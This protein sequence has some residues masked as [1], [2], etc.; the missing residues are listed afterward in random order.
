MGELKK[1]G[2][3][4]YMDEK[5]D[6]WVSKSLAGEANEREETLL[7]DVLLANEEHAR[8]YGQISEYW[9]AE[10]CTDHHLLDDVAQKMSG[11]I[12]GKRR[13]TEQR[14]L[15]LT[16]WRA[17]A[18]VLLLITCGTIMY[19]G[20]RPAKTYTCYATQENTAD[21]TLADGSFVKLNKNSTISFTGDF[22]QKDRVVELKG[23]AYFKIVKDPQKQ[24]VVKTQGT[25]TKVLGTQFNVL[26]DETAKRVTVALVKGSVRFEAAHCRQILKPEDELT[27]N[28]KTQ[29]YV[30]Q[31]PDIQFNT[32]WAEGRY[33]YRNI[34][35]GELLKK[36]EH[37]YGIN[38]E[39]QDADLQIRIVTVSLLT[40]STITDA[41]DALRDKLNFSY[42]EANGTITIEKI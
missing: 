26:S 30:K 24:F 22:G 31:L 20:A 13:H 28:V 40:N 33:Y 14:S 1:T 39:L 5:F 37:I 27:Y 41:L 42:R 32:A 29:K 35:F 16:F 23:E 11:E 34:T 17:A 2:V 21:Y 25:E 8:L 36:M 6:E 9:N 15:A 38:I 7:R 10:V 12:E 3:F 4:I 19:F 18:I